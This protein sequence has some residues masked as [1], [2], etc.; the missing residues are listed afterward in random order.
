LEDV[1]EHADGNFLSYV[2]S[3]IELSGNDRTKLFGGN[4]RQLCNLKLRYDVLGASSIG[5]EDI[6]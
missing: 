4:V 3:L 2:T 1:K 6:Q 5:V